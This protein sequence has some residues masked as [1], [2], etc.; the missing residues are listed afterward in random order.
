MVRVLE[1]GEMPETDEQTLTIS[2]PLYFPKEFL[3]R[4]ISELLDKHH[5][6]RRGKQHAKESRAK[7]KVRT[8]PNVP[9]LKRGLAVYDFRKANPEMPQWRIA[10]KF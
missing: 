9:A 2:M 4:R 6:G 8:Q 1:K 3:L 10:E 5:K 7:Y